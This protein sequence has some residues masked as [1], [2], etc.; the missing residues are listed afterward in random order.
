[1][2]RRHGNIGRPETAA[3][4]WWAKFAAAC[5]GLARAVIGE[6]SF[7]V[8]LAAA[9][10]VVAA[11]LVLRISAVEW[12]LLA[13]AISGVLAAETFN[14][15]IESLARAFDA[16]RH[17]RIRDALDMASA[18]VLLSAVT[19]AV[20]GAVVFGHRVGALTGCW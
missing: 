13:A 8:H 7:A 17:P 11:G 15:A 1:V 10:A 4:A 5:R 2:F 20:I 19:A 12:A 14:T 3:R 6:S 9:A 18:G 16:R